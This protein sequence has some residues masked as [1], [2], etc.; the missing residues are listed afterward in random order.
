MKKVFIDCGANLGQSIELFIKTWDNPKDY[1]IHCFEA[2]QDFQK[3]LNFKKQLYPDFNININ[4]PVAVW[5]KDTEG[6]LSFY[7]TLESGVVAD[8]STPTKGSSFISR[9]RGFK[10]KS[11]SLANWILNNF[12]REDYIVLKLDVEG[13]EYRIIQDF[14]NKNVLNY[15]NEFFYEWHGPKKGY[16]FKDD[17][18]ALTTLE[19]AGL[20]PKLWNGNWEEMQAKVIDKNRIKKWYERKRFKV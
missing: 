20:T 12:S 8:E 14:K 15:I 3:E 10:P 4:T 6:E 1:E 9:L 2:N 17:M 19:E 7:G 18:N 5:D 13:A 16:T 11:I